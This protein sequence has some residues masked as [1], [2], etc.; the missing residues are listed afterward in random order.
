M[1]VM[2]GRELALTLSVSVPTFD[3][4]CPATRISARRVERRVHLRL[5]HKPFTSMSS[6]RGWEL[7]DRVV[8]AS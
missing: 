7:L 2:G 5:M 6:G 4:S 8:T 3:P 1:P